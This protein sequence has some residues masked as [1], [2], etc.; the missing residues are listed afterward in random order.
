MFVSDDKIPKKGA[1]RRGKF[2]PPHGAFFL[3]KYGNFLHV[4]SV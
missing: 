1:V 3:H 2:S 4:K